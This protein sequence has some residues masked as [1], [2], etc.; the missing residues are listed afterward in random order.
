MAPVWMPTRAGSASLGRRDHRQSGVDGAPGGVFV[1]P[2]IP[3]VDQALVALARLAMAPVAFE[4]GLA[5]GF[6]A[7]Q[8]LVQL[9][10]VI[11]AC[12]VSMAADQRRDLAAVAPSGR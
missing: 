7:R 6:A 8:S 1:G 2:R 5:S 4:D 11:A 10:R 12:R 9:F 3:K